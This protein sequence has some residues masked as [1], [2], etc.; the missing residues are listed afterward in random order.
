SLR[1]LS[2]KKD[3]DYRN[4]IK[5][6]ISA[7]E[8]YC[9]IMVREPK[10]TLGKALAKIEV[11]NDIHPSLKEAFNKLYGYTSDEEGIRHKLLDAPNVK[12]EDAVFMLVACS[13]FIN[14]LKQKEI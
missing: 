13:A 9:S 8:S 11:K 7:V 12:Q 4:S 10:A 5:E 1:M 14:Y 6:S 3:P 2:D